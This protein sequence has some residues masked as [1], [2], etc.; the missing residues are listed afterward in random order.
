[1]AF[2]TGKEVKVWVCTETTDASQKALGVIQTSTGKNKMGIFSQLF[3]LH[4][5]YHK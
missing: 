1:M 4:H 2:Y 5:T 3:Q